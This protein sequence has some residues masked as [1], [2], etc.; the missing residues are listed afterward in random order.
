MKLQNFFILYRFPMFAI[1]F[2]VTNCTRRLRL[3]YTLI[4]IV[5][6]ALIFKRPMLIDNLHIVTIVSIF[7]NTITGVLKR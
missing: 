3:M 7:E 5:L 1:P 6:N 2:S 4:A